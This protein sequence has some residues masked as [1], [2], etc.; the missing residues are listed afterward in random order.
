MDSNSRR[1]EWLTAGLL[2]ASALAFYWPVTLY[3]LSPAQGDIPQQFL[4]WKQFWQNSLLQGRIPLWNP[5]VACG[6]PFLANYQSGVFNP[7]DW[8]LLWSSP[9]RFF[10]SSLLIHTLAALLGTYGLAR[11]LRLSPG[12]AFLASIVYAFSGFNAIHLFA[13]NFLTFSA[14]VWFPPLAWMGEGLTGSVRSG[15]N[16]KETLRWALGLCAALALQVLAGHPQL[17]FYSLVFTGIWLLARAWPGREG[18]GLRLGRVFGLAACAGLLAACACAAQ[19]L[20]TLEY[21]GWSSR[22]EGLNYDEATQFS[23]SPSR[24]LALP[25]PDLFGSQAT[26]NYWAYWKDWS[27]AYMGVWPPLLALIALAHAVKTWRIRKTIEGENSFPLTACLALALAAVILA[28]GRHHSLYR[29]VMQL[30]GFEYFRAPSKFLPYFILPLALL[31]GRGWDL[32]GQGKIPTWRVWVV[33]PLL[34]LVAGGLAILLEGNRFSSAS[35]SVAMRAGAL[36]LGIY[37]AGLV[38]LLCSFRLKSRSGRG[39]MTI[40]FLALAL[41]DLYGYSAKYFQFADLRPRLDWLHR[42]FAEPIASDGS[43]RVDA[44]PAIGP[45]EAMA[46]GAQTAGYYDPMSIHH[47]SQWIRYYEGLPPEGFS[48]SLV[49]GD[50]S[51]AAAPLVSLRYRLLLEGERPGWKRVET[52]LPEVVFYP[53]SLVQT[54]PYPWN[55]NPFE[56]LYVAPGEGEAALW[57]P[58]ALDLSEGKPFSRDP[59]L[60][61]PRTMLARRL[62]PEIWEIEYRSEESGHFY[63]SQVYYPGWEYRLD[64]GEYR[65]V[66]RANY[67]FQAVPAPEGGHTL[68]IEYRPAS[69]RVGLW[70]S[71]AG[72]LVLLGAGWRLRKRKGVHAENGNHR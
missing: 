53:D 62:S 20:P 3:G 38:F 61:P 23:F 32:L 35:V 54:A 64:G 60:V 10:G 30:P 34:M 68:R 57:P 58:P 16:R 25:L 44:S 24:L 43:G 55:I 2:A 69:F 13:G 18:R 39:W 4:P 42:V 28:M 17:F 12:A 36:A 19:L 66:L 11:Q 9:E 51:G 72:W 15:T 47:Y 27:S 46:A 21:I 22:G 5:F 45:N 65:P 7:M 33:L 49:P 59:R 40:L 6:C 71:L 31:A 14:A 1:V 52:T 8:L 29:L 41:G 70:I 67:A 56:A 48:D 63:L 50:F 26:R 37:A